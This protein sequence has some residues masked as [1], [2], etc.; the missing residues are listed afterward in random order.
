M[1]GTWSNGDKLE[2]AGNPGAFFGQIVYCKLKWLN[3]LVNPSNN[4]SN[5]PN[6]FVN[7]PNYFLNPSNSLLNLSNLA[8]RTR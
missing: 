8:P 7:P 6:N 1:F 2:G 5:P 4:F 3:K